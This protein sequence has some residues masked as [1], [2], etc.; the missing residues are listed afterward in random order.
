MLILLCERTILVLEKNNNKEREI[1][2]IQLKIEMCMNH[3]KKYT[4]THTHSNLK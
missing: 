3:C 4:H 2:N 1:F